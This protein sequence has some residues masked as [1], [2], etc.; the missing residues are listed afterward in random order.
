[1]LFF[2]YAPPMTK[3]ADHI[4]AEL[5]IDTPIV[6]ISIRMLTLN[7]PPQIMDDL[8]ILLMIHLLDWV[9]VGLST[10][11]ELR[12]SLVHFAEAW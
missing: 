8:Q 7:Q 10:N 12:S 11:V 2:S 9:P 5:A 4:C 6:S 3:A 1:M